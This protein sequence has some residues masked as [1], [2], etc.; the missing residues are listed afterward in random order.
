MCSLQNI[1]L[2]ALTGWIPERISITPRQATEEAN[3]V[4][5]R[6][7][8]GL[9]L[10]KC[11]ITVATGE[12][13]TDTELRTGLV[14]THAYA[15]LDMKLINGVRLLQLKNPWSHL[16]WKGNYSEKDLQNW[17]IELQRY[18]NYDPSRAEK[19]DNGI[20]WIDFHSVINFFDVFYINWD[21][22]LFSHTYCVHQMWNA[23]VGPTKDAYTVSENPQFILKIG[24]G[25]GSVWVLLTR[26]ITSIDDFRNNR[27]YISIVAYENGGRKV[28]YPCKLTMS[29]S[30]D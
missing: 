8:D 19:D 16:R 2:N 1:D 13:S 7:C 4:F 15:V 14:S 23:G 24:P 10:G 3:A 26:H 25:C 21:P 17:T 29:L 5:D 30:I 20:F 22:T 28:F 9:A 11:L 6:L 18:L 12:M 27:E